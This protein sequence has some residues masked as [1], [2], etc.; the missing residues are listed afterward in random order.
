MSGDV[1]IL[2]DSVPAAAPP[3][4]LDTLVQATSVRAALEALGFTSESCAVSADLEALGRRLAERRPSV[5]FNLVESLAGTDAGMIAVP[6]LLDGLGIPYT[7]SPAAACAVV[8]DKPAAKHL[9]RGLGLPTPPWFTDTADLTAGFEPGR[10][11]VKACFEHASVGFDEDGLLHWEQLEAAQH[12]YAERRR[13]LGRPCFAEAYIEGREF[14]VSLLADRNGVE[15][16][17]PAEI[18]FSAY[19]AAKP[20]VVGYRAKWI[21]DSFEY[22]N[23]PRSFDFARSD[24]PLLTTLEQLARTAFELLGLRGY[25]RVDFRV[26]ERG[27]WIL[28]LNANPCLSPDAGFAAALARAGI[29]YKTAIGRIVAT[30]LQHMDGHVP[31]TPHS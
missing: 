10:Y 17:P 31:N 5:V 6:A 28:E 29:D 30:A 24:A 20:R 18:D 25:A 11:V 13:L 1:L 16:L 4:A 19:P 21:A 2:H 23:T 15:V 7:G 3:E 22:R 26:D 8:N 27:P 9:L 12:A 14:N